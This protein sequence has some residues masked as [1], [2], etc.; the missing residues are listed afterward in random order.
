[1]KRG[2]YLELALFDLDH[3]LLSVDSDYEWGQF[4]IETGVLDRDFYESENRRYYEDYKAGRLDIHEF[5][6]FALAPLAR[7]TRTQL[8]A[9]HA[10]FME[11]KIRPMIRG[12]GRE[13]IARHAAQGSLC[14]IITATNAFVTA[15]IARD[16]GVAHLIATEPEIV[17]GRFTGR[18]LGLPCFR[19][20]KIARLEQWLASLGK[21]WGAFSASRFYSDSHNDLPLLEK[22]THPVAVDPDDLLRKIALERRWKVISLA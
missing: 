6:G 17:G 1:M 8:D 16:L 15:P 14:A 19:E 22:V 12:K 9:W 2:R 20:G 11:R 10:A 18:P 7:F 21:N 4:L 5:L 13:L 3:T